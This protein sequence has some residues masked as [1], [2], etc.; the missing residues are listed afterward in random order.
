MPEKKPKNPIEPKPAVG[1]APVLLGSLGFL[2]NKPANQLRERLDPLLAPFGLSGKLLS[3]LKLLDAEGV[4]TQHEIC[5]LGRVDRSTVVVLVD[6]L[7][8]QGL[9]ERGRKPGDRRAHA[10]DLT[11]K[12]RGVLAKARKIEEKVQT[13]FLACL[14][15]DE[16]RTLM[17]LLARLIQHSSKESV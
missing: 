4:Q 10:V 7:E 9:V 12:G 8:Q 16:R 17:A 1:P 3:V 13:E 5:G 2:L 15:A 11:A 6:A 14:G